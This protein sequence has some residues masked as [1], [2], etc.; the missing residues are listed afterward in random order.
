MPGTDIGI[1][2]S[3]APAARC[4]GLTYRRCQRVEMKAFSAQVV[5]EMWG[6]CLIRA[7]DGQVLLLARGV[8]E[9]AQQAAG[10]AMQRAEEEEARRRRRA[11]E[12]QQ[13]RR[14]RRAAEEEGASKRVGADE[15]RR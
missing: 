15:E 14:R 12:E 13:Q 4:P 5:P 10:S 1:T 11:E 8:S 7:C 9:A 2:V 6:V 3:Y